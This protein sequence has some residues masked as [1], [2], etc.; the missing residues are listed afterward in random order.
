MEEILS[1]SALTRLIK[2]NLEA[3]FPSVTVEGEISGYKLASSGHLY[4]SL[5]DRDALIQAVMFKYRASFLDFSPMDGQ[6]VVA[7]GGLS[8]YPAR[9]QYQLIVQSMR[10]SGL[11]DILAMIEERKKRLAAEGLFDSERKRPLP[12]R[13]SKVGVVTSPTGAAVRDILNVLS[14]RNSGIDILILPAAVQGAGAAET[15]A[16]RIRQANAMGGIDVLIVGRGGGS[17]EDLLAFSDEEVVRAIAS[18][19][20]PVISA[21][22]HEIDWALSDY[23]ADLRAPTP[24]AAAEM[25]AESS[26]ALR[27]EVDLHER[28]LATSVL[29]RLDYVRTGI[30]IF[31]REDVEVRFQRLFMPLSRRFDEARECLA[32]AAASALLQREHRIELA[33]ASLE[34][35]NPQSVLERGYSIVRL[36]AAHEGLGRKRGSNTASGTGQ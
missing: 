18:S 21:V 25:V 35:A 33:T 36:E 28:T 13:P 6:K 31:S 15:I 3:S 7:R 32:S 1:V 5:K 11:G 27:K 10:A 24:S 16:A 4:F 19:S 34:L 17:P 12:R 9:G 8:L 29:A 22:G 30:E 26:L 2:G 14:R 20:I 23:A